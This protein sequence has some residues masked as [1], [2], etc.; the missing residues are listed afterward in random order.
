MQIG[1]T[2]SVVSIYNRRKINADEQKSRKEELMS[3]LTDRASYLKGLADGMDLN[4]E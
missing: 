3:K 4:M 2:H 1:T